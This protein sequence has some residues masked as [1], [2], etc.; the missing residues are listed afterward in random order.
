MPSY[1]TI[2]RQRKKDIEDIEKNKKTQSKVQIMTTQ[3]KFYSPKP[4]LSHDVR[5][6]SQH[7]YLGDNLKSAVRCMHHHIYTHTHTLMI[8]WLHT[9]IRKYNLLKHTHT[10]TQSQ[11]KHSFD[12]IFLFFFYFSHIFL[13]LNDFCC[14]RWH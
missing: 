11:C 6:K 5:Y 4:C 8:I 3:K 2:I 13:S 10:H 14:I 7:L 9:I 1:T 12:C